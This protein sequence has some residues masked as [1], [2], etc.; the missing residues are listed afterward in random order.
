MIIFTV[1]VALDTPMVGI[2][3]FIFKGLSEGQISLWMLFKFNFLP[4]STTI[5]FQEQKFYMNWPPLV[6]GEM[7]KLK[8]GLFLHGGIH[9]RAC[10]HK[11]VNLCVHLCLWVIQRLLDQEASAFSPMSVLKAN[12]TTQ[13]QRRRSPFY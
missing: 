13:Y 8:V 5:V 2:F 7:L 11:S 6:N 3:P 4:L 9:L 1:C 12:P 10:V